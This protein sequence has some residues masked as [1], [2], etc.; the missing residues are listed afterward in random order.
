M[1]LE[2]VLFSP[3]VQ[4]GF[5]PLHDPLDGLSHLRHVN[6]TLSCDLAAGLIARLAVVAPCHQFGIA[7]DDQISVVTDEDNLSLLLGLPELFYDFLH[8]RIV[9][10]FF[11]LVDKERWPGLVQ[12]RLE[13]GRGL[14]S[15]RGVAERNVVILA[16]PIL[17]YRFALDVYK[18]KGEPVFGR[19]L[20]GNSIKIRSPESS[21]RKGRSIWSTIS[22]ITVW[23]KRSQLF[24]VEEYVGPA[25]LRDIGLYYRRSKRLDPF[26]ANAR[27]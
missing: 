22:A 3:E 7:V 26:P 8:D 15:S 6:S 4:G 18:G 19:E 11:R 10:V 12:E 13:Q 16:G 14:L 20:A 17:E 21:G 27:P 5:T 1:P 25:F 9:E 24:Q 23:I 2:A